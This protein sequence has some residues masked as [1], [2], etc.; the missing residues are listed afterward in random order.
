MSFS[1]SALRDVLR[2]G[3]DPNFRAD[4]D[5]GRTLLHLSVCEALKVRDI[6][7]VLLLLQHKANPNLPDTQGKIP[8]IEAIEA[9]DVRMARLLIR[10]NADVNHPSP[11]NVTPLHEAVVK[12]MTE[13]TQLLLLHNACVNAGERNGRTP[14]FF[15]HSTMMCEM[16]VDNGADI[17]HTGTKGDTALHSA[18]RG[19]SSATVRYLLQHGLPVNARDDKDY[20]PLHCA[21][22]KGHSNVIQVLLDGG[23][24]LSLK[25][26]NGQDSLDIADAY[27]FK[28]LAFYMYCRHT[29]SNKASWRE[30]MNNPLFLML[31]SIMGTAGFISR[32]V[33]MD[34]AYDLMGW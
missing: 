13:M 29:G 18:A 33:I 4:E 5:R 6:S 1:L 30:R 12:D 10:H 26:K 3:C 28:D 9:N 16:L 2:K 23:G 22:Q 27:D 24:D 8:L 14:I 11:L 7:K 25:T 20:T 21:S 34:V 31:C 17:L 15:S 32:A 19:G